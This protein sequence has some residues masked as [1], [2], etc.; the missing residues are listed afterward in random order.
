M[1]GSEFDAGAE[2]IEERAAHM[3][4]HIMEEFKGMLAGAFAIEGVREAI[5]GAIEFGEQIKNTAT[6]LGVSTTA[7]Q[8][9]SFAAKQTGIDLDQVSGGMDRLAKGLTAMEDGTAAGGKIVE[10]FHRLGIEAAELKG[11]SPEEVMRLLGERMEH[12][13]VTGEVT[14]S[15]L[16]I[17]GRSGAKLIPMLKDLGENVEAAHDK[18]L[19]LDPAAVLALDEAAKTIDQL[20]LKTKVWAAEG[21]VAAKLYTTGLYEVVKAALT[22]KETLATSE[23][24]AHAAAMEKTLAAQKALKEAGT[25]GPSHEVDFT[26]TDADKKKEADEAGRLNE[27]TAKRQTKR[28]DERGTVDQRITREEK[29]QKELQDALKRIHAETGGGGLAGADMRNQLEKSKDK[30]DGLYK[31]HLKEAFKKPETHESHRHQGNVD[32]LNRMGGFVGGGANPGLDIAHQ[33]L[34][35]QRTIAANTSPKN[36]PTGHGD[37]AP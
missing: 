26:G 22:I 3:G 16:E 36:S 32:H 20:T 24:N 23:G 15:M 28:E 18:G 11:K 14:A 37:I 5:M 7:A 27:D 9:F 8:E 21:V 25:M 2:K 19:I 34:A 12:L 33:Q 1:D 13:T 30:L 10:A 4:E 6:R 35:V 31:E 29:N 17:F